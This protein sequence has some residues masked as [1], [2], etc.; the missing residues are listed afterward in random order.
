MRLFTLCNIQVI[1]RWPMF[2]GKCNTWCIILMNTMWVN[3]RLTVSIFCYI[4]AQICESMITYM[5]GMIG[6]TAIPLWHVIPN[7]LLFLLCFTVYTQCS[8]VSFMFYSLYPMLRCF[9]Y[10]LQ[11]PNAP[12][13]LLCFTVTQCS[14]VSFMF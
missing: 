12:L 2:D 7:A 3:T 9:F 6:D 11:L 4:N 8:A 13:F 14:A 5:N 10:V 1:S